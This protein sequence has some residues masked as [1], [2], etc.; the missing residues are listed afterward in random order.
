MIYHLIIY[1]MKNLETFLITIFVIIDD[2]YKLILPKWF[3]SKPGTKSEFTE[4]EVITFA[5][6]QEACDFAS[7]RRFYNLFKKHFKYLF[8]KL[9]DR[10]QINR[11]IKG[12]RYVIEWI[13]HQLLKMIGITGDEDR[14]VDS[15][16]MPTVHFKRAHYSPLFKDKGHYGYCASKDEKYFGFKLH[17]MTTFQGIPTDFRIT[18]ANVDDRDALTEILE[19]YQGIN[20]IGDTG[21][22][23][24]WWQEE[25][26]EK[27]NINLFTPK[28]SNQKKQ[29]P[30]FINRLLRKTRGIIETVNEQ[31]KNQFNLVATKTRN[32]LS[33]ETKVLT[34][35]T[36]FTLCIYL[37]LISG[38][39][40]LATSSLVF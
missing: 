35:I 32:Y 36:A 24:E 19:Y 18:A 4:S 11:R 40:L 26:R 9:V 7:Q 15:T 20:I 37:N 23:R 5:L 29:N 39:D 22:L 33:L 8:S 17:L 31:L 2:L 14:V 13:R 1:K 25:L 10:T 16:P 27:K 3:K 6:A 34:K 30:S 28:R 21:Y 38:N 12:L